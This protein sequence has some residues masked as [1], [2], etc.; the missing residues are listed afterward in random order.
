MRKLKRGEHARHKIYARRANDWAARIAIGRRR[1][2]AAPRLGHEER[3]G[4]FVNWPRCS[5]PWRLRPQPR[6]SQPQVRPS[7]Q[8]ST[9]PSWMYEEQ[10]SE[11]FELSWSADSTL[12]PQQKSRWLDFSKGWRCERV[13]RQ[14]MPCRPTCAQGWSKVHELCWEQ[15]TD[16]EC[17][18]GSM[19][20]SHLVSNPLPRQ[21]LPC[22]RDLGR[23]STG[24]GSVPAHA[25]GEPFQYK[26]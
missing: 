24:R 9:L 4:S 15:S 25:E 21:E 22:L 6:H 18:Q 14:R 1:P 23:Q 3:Q 11:S 10:E 17:Y 26:A 20:H 2:Q 7:Q 13:R 19:P 16:A 8:V 5:C 12:S